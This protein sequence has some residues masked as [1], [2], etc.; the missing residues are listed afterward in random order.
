[1]KAESLLIADDWMR[2]RIASDRDVDTEAGSPLA[3]AALLTD[4]ARPD[5]NEHERD[6][7]AAN[8]N[9]PERATDSSAEQ[10]DRN[11]Q[12]DRDRHGQKPITRI[13]V[14]T[15]TRR[16]T[17][18]GVVSRW[19][20]ARGPFNLVL[21]GGAPGVDAEADRWCNSKGHCQSVASDIAVTSA[22]RAARTA[23]PR[24]LTLRSCSR[25]TESK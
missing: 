7:G 24:W 25:T 2:R 11:A 9:P 16:N 23:T 1:M 21:H 14:V 12:K 3:L 19:L 22:L 10:D 18:R 15:G 6:R 13:A 20:D 4:T 8:G 5:E 17:R